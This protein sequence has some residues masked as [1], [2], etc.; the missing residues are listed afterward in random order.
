MDL[1][2]NYPI[3]G[4]LKP[5]AKSFGKRGLLLS[6]EEELVIMWVTQNFSRQSN[7]F[8]FLFTLLPTQAVV[9]QNHYPLEEYSTRWWGTVEF[10]KAL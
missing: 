9:E 10:E 7:V 8:L 4:F 6:Y 3:C 5:R 2:R 1:L